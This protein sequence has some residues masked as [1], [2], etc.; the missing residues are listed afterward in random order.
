[1]SCGCTKPK[2]A[3]LWTPAAEYRQPTDIQPGE[4]I[5]CY[6]KRAGNQGGMDLPLGA[7]AAPTPLT[8]DRIDNTSLTSDLAL[9]VETTMKVTPG[10][11]SVTSWAMEIK[12]NGAVITIPG[13][14]ITS[15]GLISCTIPDTYANRNFKVMITAIFANGATDSREFNFFPK[16]ANK[17]GI[18]KFVIPL[19]GNTRVT[20]KFGPRSPPAAGAS[21]NHK[22]MDFA[23]TDRSLGNILAAADGTVVRCGPGSGWGNVIFIEHNDAQ[24]RLVATTVYGHW[25]QAY[26]AQGQKV[27]AGQKIAKEGNV[28]IGSGAH[29]HFEL[30]K[31]KFGNPTD[32]A[33]YLNGATIIDDPAAGGSEPSSH[34]NAGMVTGEANSNGDCPGSTSG[35]PL[36]N[37]ALPNNSGTPTP[38]VVVPADKAAVAAEILRAC[39]DHGPYAEG[40][41]E[42][43]FL[44]SLAKI[45]SGF[46]PAAK[47]PTSSAL[48]L[49]QMLDSIA[50]RYFGLIGLS[51]TTANRTDPYKSTWAM[52]KFYQNEFVKY[53]NEYSAHGTLAGKAIQTTNWSAQYPNFNKNEFLYGLIHHDGVGTAVSGIDKGG[54][55]YWRKT[56]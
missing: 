28:G 44:L 23:R 47:N 30:H 16:T 48:G 53:W 55:A 20:C 13:M 50:A 6:M 21:S 27:A 39:Q 37:Q 54:V 33:P 2:P 46:N 15:G 7:D 4:N 45:E 31:G 22:G 41:E 38:D 3:A 43:K 32:P 1:M 10:S 8:V 5:D 19:D 40:S 49:Y 9:K 14:S 24:G 18:I 52:I 51:P 35:E 25:S 29:L 26:V 34:A 56:A 11:Q 12:E 42:H 36:P 17:D